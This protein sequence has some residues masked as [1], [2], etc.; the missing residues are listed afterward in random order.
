MKRLLSV[1]LLLLLLFTGCVSKNSVRIGFWTNLSGLQSQYG[2]IGRNGVELHSVVREES[3][4]FQNLTYE[5]DY[6]SDENNDDIAREEIIKN[7]D[8]GTKIMIAHT[9]SQR[10]LNA[11]DVV[12]ASDMIFLGTIISTEKMY[13]VDDNF[14]SLIPVVDKQGEVLAKHA[15]EED[16]KRVVLVYDEF[17]SNYTKRLVDAYESYYSENGGVVR[18]VVAFDSRDAFD[19]QELALKIQS[20]HPDHVVIASGTIESS[21][22]AQRLKK[23]DGELYIY[24]GLSAMNDAYLWNVGD[25]TSNI[26]FSGTYD[27][28]SDSPAMLAFR[29]KYEDYYGSMPTYSAC[30]SYDAMSVS[31]DVINNVK[32]IDEKNIKEYLLSHE[33][34]GLMG[35][36]VFDSYGDTQEDYHIFS[37]EDGIF[38]KRGD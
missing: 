8:L 23:G 3:G 36:I 10:F 17:N 5:I 16:L 24:H 12:N 26:Y 21:L 27:I 13:Q 7:R 4:L 38:R 1:V 35:P 30:Y 37:I 2:I 20:A 9:S 25:D 33:F 18:K 34:E 14:F 31:I 15:L 19:F 28:N 32:S 29:K 6:I 11:L 22:L